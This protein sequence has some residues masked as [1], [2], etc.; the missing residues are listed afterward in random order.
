MDPAKLLSVAQEGGFWSYIAGVAYQILTHYHVKGIE[1]DNYKTDLPIKKGLSSSAAACVLVTRAFNRIYDLKMTTRG[2][3]EMAYRGEITSPSRCGRMDQGCAYGS[4]PLLMIFDGD[5]ITV[6]EISIPRALYYV[7][8]DLKSSKDTIRILTDLNRAYPFAE[9][10]EQRIVQKYLGPTNK[11][12]IL[13]ALDAMQSGDAHQL[14]ALTVEAQQCFDEA[15]IPACPQELTAPVLHKTLS[16]RKIASYVL[17]GKGVGSQGD[18]TAQFFVEDEQAQKAVVR[19]IEDELGLE[20]LTLRIPKSRKVRKAII[21][22]AG[23]GTRLFPMTRI[24]RKEFMPIIDKKGIIKP[25][26]LQHMQD[27]HHSEIEKVAFIIQD[28]DKRYFDQLAKE[29]VSPEVYKKLS[30]EN[31]NVCDEIMDM[32]ADISYVA[33]NEQKGLGHAV[34]ASR[35]WVGEEPFL[36]VLGDHYFQANE[37]SKSCIQQLIDVYHKLDDSV[38]GLAYASL[39]DVQRFGCVAGKWEDYE[40]VLS[41]TEITEKPSPEYAQEH[42]IVEGMRD[43]WFLTAFGLYLLSPDIFVVLEEMLVN[44]QLENH[45]LQL[46]TALEILR[47]RK[48]LR[49]V[50]IHGERTDIGTPESY[51]GVFKGKIDSP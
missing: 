32:G 40:E 26:M 31:Q 4:K 27:C 36:L 8:V 2:E 37:D 14:G 50:M 16:N 18:G 20:C 25:L 46:T 45:E 7:I 42:L 44:G 29:P 21:T 23:H 13:S 41:I 22:A 51:R 38:I 1:I 5:T 43:G 9:N 3:M 17:G 35:N 48:G 34:L 11:R 24:L 49:G 10:E 47:R 12:I 39:N 28:R 15:L 19:I 30:T 6:D 33:Q